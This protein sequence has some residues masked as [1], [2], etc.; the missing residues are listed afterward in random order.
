MVNKFLRLL[1]LLVLIFNSCTDIYEVPAEKD[2]T[3]SFVVFSDLQQGYGVFSHLAL[4]ISNLEPAP[5]AAFCCGDI[6]SRSANESQWV[7]FTHCAEPIRQKM[8]LLI[9]RGN[10]ERNDSAS[11]SLLHQYGS[12]ASNRF[13]Y[14]HTER[15]TL[16]IVLDTYE[17][18]M[19]GAILGDQLAW[20][21]H[22]LDSASSE[23]SINHIFIIM[24]QPLYPQGRHKG[25]DLSNANE[26]HQ[27]FLKHKKIRAVFSGHD[28]MFNKYVKDG[29]IYI[30]TGGGGGVLYRG[31]GG[32]YH[33]FLKVSF[34]NDTTRINVKTI[35]IFNEIIE[36]FDL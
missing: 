15:N 10:H 8:P 20:L 12:I 14:S 7:S 5:R 3:W 19:E 11:E 21:K 2:E 31:Y 1:I 29:M 16:F 34:F 35:D 32:D 25:E 17:R 4:N 23:P 9:A 24:H 30:T 22:Q 33:H 26:L 6:M 28:H 18:G 13:Y 36:E 27:L